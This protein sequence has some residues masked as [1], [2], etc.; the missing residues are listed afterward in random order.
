MLGYTRAAFSVINGE[1]RMAC[2]GV[3]F[4][5]P[6]IQVAAL[7]AKVG[8]AA[9]LAFLQ[10]DIEE[11]YF[12]DHQDD[13]AESDKAWDA[14]HRALAGGTL[15]AD[16]PYP[17]GLA[18]LAGEQLYGG[19]DYIMS[20]KSPAQVRDI[21]TAL[22]AITESGFRRRYFA[23]DSNDY[24]MDLSEEDFAYTWESF[25]DVRALYKRAA[26]QGRYVLFSVDQ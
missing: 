22:D 6:E 12:N 7:R 5:L 16:S 17:F 19:D 2:R 13:L 14:M 21:A 4:A 20:L 11:R 3:H 18:V 1:D 9:R 8:D 24:E 10:E 25:E 15:S 26:Q 23:I